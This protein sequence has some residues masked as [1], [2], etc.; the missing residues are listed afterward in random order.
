MKVMLITTFLI[1]A[2]H[3][4][5]ATFPPLGITCESKTDR[6][7]LILKNESSDLVHIRIVS[8]TNNVM[9]SGGR[10]NSSSSLT[11]SKSQFP[12]TLE[13]GHSD[14]LVIQRNCDIE[15]QNAS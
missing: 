11:L 15:T 10:G 12:V 4:N 14:P 8:S 5:A 13:T 1:A 9:V 7:R 2:F 3:V 6:V